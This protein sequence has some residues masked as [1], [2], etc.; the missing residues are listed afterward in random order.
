[1]NLNPEAEVSTPYTY[2]LSKD[3]TGI[4]RFRGKPTVGDVERLI[5]FLTLSKSA[6]PTED[7]A[8]SSNGE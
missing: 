4:V 7:P 5:Q 6:F 8:R 1:M 2:P 3:C